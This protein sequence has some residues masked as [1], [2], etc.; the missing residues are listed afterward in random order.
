M[1]HQIVR[2]QLKPSTLIKFVLENDSILS[3]NY[4]RVRGMNA[5]FL[6]PMIYKKAS[7]ILTLVNSV[8]F[9]LKMSIMIGQ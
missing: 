4:L 7:L 1:G 8:V 6:K 5:E 2:A 9:A 3:M